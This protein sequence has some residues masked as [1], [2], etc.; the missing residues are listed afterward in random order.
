LAAASPMPLDPPVMTAIFPF[1]LAV[2]QSSV[3]CGRAPPF[4]ESDAVLKIS[5]V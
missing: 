2:T 1:S 3:V 5:I 4:G